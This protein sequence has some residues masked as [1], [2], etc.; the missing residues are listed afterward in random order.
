MY[1]TSMYTEKLIENLLLVTVCKFRCLY[2][3]NQIVT[4]IFS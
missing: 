3:D 1:V 2:T 4:D